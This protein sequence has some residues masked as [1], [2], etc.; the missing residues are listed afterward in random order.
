MRRAGASYNEILKEVLVA[1]STLSAWLKDL[2]LTKNERLYLKKRTN[3]N[4][5]RGRVK[6]A[7]ENRAHRCE[8]VR[9]LV[10]EQSQVFQK[11]VDDAMFHLGI[12]LYWAEGSNKAPQFLFVNSDPEMVTFMYAWIQKYL[13]VK[14]EDIGIRVYMHT[15][16]SQSECEKYWANLLGREIRSF[17]KTIFKPTDRTAKHN[18]NYRGCVRLE[19]SGVEKYR[20][21]MAWKKCLKAYILREISK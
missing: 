10:V 6:A 11:N 4:I 8:R 14:A 12:S 18:V 5:S 15:M 17:K 3:H 19:V 9:Q 16:Y 13:A 20:T 21:M 7:S 1:K 2:P